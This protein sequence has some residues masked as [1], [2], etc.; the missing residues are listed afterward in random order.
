MSDKLCVID[1]LPEQI[2]GGRITLR[3]P[4]GVTDATVLLVMPKMEVPPVPTFP[5]PISELL[6]KIPSLYRGKVMR[7]LE[8]YGYATVQDF[9]HSSEHQGQSGNPPLAPNWWLEI[10]RHPC[11][12]K[13][14]IL[15]LQH[16]LAQLGW[17]SEC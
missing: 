13:K 10:G 4:P 8:Y 1:V 15:R 16:A 3:L 5:V 9:I 6:E 17:P 2:V 7:F 12:G 11:I 14:T